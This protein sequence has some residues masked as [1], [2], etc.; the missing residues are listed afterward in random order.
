MILL[1]LHIP[2]SREKRKREKKTEKKKKSFLTWHPLQTILH[3]SFAQHS[4]FVTQVL[5]S[6]YNGSD[7]LAKDIASSWSLLV[8]PIIN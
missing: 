7:E 1:Q 6:S 4:K 2:L 5:S 8:L 3:C